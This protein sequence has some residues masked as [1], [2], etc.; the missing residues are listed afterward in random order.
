MI[1]GARDIRRRTLYLHIFTLIE[2]LIVIVIIAI[3]AALLLPALN[4]AREKAHTAACLSN[5]RQIGIGYTMYANANKDYGPMTT[6][7][8]HLALEWMDCSIISQ[9]KTLWRERLAGLL[10][11]DGYL[12]P[13]V[14]RCPAFK[15]AVIE[16]GYTA[17]DR[18]FRPN[19]WN[20]TD[21]IVEGNYV[22]RTTDL[23]TYEEM[24]P[25]FD[26]AA[27]SAW[28]YKLGNSPKAAITW[29]R[30]TKELGP[31]WAHQSVNAGYEDGSAQSIPNLAHKMIMVG[32]T[33]H[34]YSINNGDSKLYATKEAISRNGKYGRMFC[35]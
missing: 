8:G 5:V 13:N 23:K 16:Q 24:Q 11:A 10:C 7:Q 20:K 33:S 35:K 15:D 22:L 1:S 2:L 19:E 29:D 30:A 14:M 31:E 26:T 18:I 9:N 28:G 4:K 17:N 3:L 34:S 25:S 32:L 12:T 21:K 6:A 27:M